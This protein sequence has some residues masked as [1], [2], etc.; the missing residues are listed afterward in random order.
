MVSSTA[1]ILTAP[2]PKKVTTMPPSPAR[3]WAHAAPAAIGT[4]PPTIALVPR[5]PASGQRKCIEPPR[6]LQ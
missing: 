6:P 2:S 3:C 1:P 4:P 5:Q